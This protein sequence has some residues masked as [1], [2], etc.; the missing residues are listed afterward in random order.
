MENND[1]KV[2]PKLDNMKK[3]IIIAGFLGIALILLS[4]VFS[5]SGDKSDIEISIPEFDADAYRI[6]LE[7][8]LADIIS[9]IDG[10]GNTGVMITLE[11]GREYV[12]AQ[13]TRHD[14]CS[15]SDNVQ[16]SG[17]SEYY[18]VKSDSNGETPIL[19]YEREPKVR[20][21]I[22]VCSGGDNEAVREKITEAV[23]GIFDISKTNISVSKISQ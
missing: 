21:V 12:Y 11:G 17:E 4:N 10:A 9:H 13:N 7:S 23:A 6:E 3:A 15:D 8:R 19:V 20:G 2:L 18:T 14:T 5:S 16:S 1:K 22:V